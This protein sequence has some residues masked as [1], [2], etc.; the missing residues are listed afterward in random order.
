LSLFAGGSTDFLST[1]SSK[2]S[3]DYTNLKAQ[4]AKYLGYA[5]DAKWTDDTKCSW[6]PTLET[7]TQPT[8]KMAA[9]HGWIV[10]SCSASHLKIESTDSW[11]C[12]SRE[13]VVCTD[14]GGKCDVSLSGAI[15]TTQ[16]DICG[17]YEVASGG[18]TCQST[19]DCG[20]NGQ[21]KESDGVK[22]C[23]CLSCYT[24]SDCSVKDISSC[25]TLTSSDSAPQAIF[26][27][28]GAF[29]GVMAVV[30]IALGVAAA[31]KHADTTRLARQVK[32]GNNNEPGAAA[33]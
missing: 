29:L 22:S 20:G 18:G 9:E 17:A 24:G 23:S 5:D 10:S 11:V 28:V 8:N 4:F 1:P 32:A 2:P 3:K 6:S 26:V 15:G 27:G 33:M 30:F 21:C 14:D 13:G 31:K 16:E 25:A 12:S 19:S 7:K